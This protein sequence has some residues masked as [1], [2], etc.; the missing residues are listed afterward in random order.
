ML[1]IESPILPSFCLVFRHHPA[2]SA[3]LQLDQKPVRV[4]GAEAEKAK[5]VALEGLKVKVS[6]PASEAGQYETG[7][8]S[9][10]TCSLG[11]GSCNA[12]SCGMAGGR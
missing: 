6:D 10:A 8:G 7:P 11:S 5:V 1:I 3:V 9:P 2:W 4:D 12:G